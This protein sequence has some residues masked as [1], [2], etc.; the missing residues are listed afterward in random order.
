MQEKPL[1]WKDILIPHPPAFV[2]RSLAAT[3]M[4]VSKQVTLF[5][6]LDVRVC[7]KNKK[8]ASYN[9]SAH[10]EVV[11]FSCSTSL[12]IFPS[13]APKEWLLL[14]WP[15]MMLLSGIFASCYEKLTSGAVVTWA[16]GEKKCVGFL[17]TEQEK[18]PV[19][20]VWV[21][22]IMQNSFD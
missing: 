2:S 19:L 13:V 18:Q 16:A 8:R 22:Y 6:S 20:E 10:L 7:M 3:L 4:L 21:K 15:V 12:F 9:F 17:L 11:M 14:Q 5:F 1:N